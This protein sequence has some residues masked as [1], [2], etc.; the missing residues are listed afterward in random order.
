MKELTDDEK[1]SMMFW[2][3][4]IVGKVCTPAT[5]FVPLPKDVEAWMDSGIPKDFIEKL[6]ETVDKEGFGY[7]VFMRTDLLAGKHS[8]TET[9]YVARPELIGGNC[10][11]LIE[12]NL[13]ADFLGGMNPKAIVLREFLELDAPFKAFKDMPIAREFRAFVEDGVICCIHPYW[14]PESIEFRGSDFK[15]RFDAFTKQG[16]SIDEAF[17]RVNKQGPL[18]W[19]TKLAEISELPALE[20]IGGILE[21]VSRLVPGYWSVDICRTK[22]GVW[23]VTD[24]AVG[25]RS[26]HW[27]GCSKAKKAIQ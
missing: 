1:C 17:K 15:E 11:R 24:M 2:F 26:F 13:M 16:L 18:G 27:E 6:R 23:M 19:E 12:E 8:W 14:P 7:P 25:E 4:L 22:T 21:E 20:T 5:A 3:P 10:Y 9:C